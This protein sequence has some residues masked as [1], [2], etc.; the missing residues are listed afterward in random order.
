MLKRL[1]NKNNKK[2]MEQTLAIRKSPSDVETGLV[3]RTNYEAASGFNYLTGIRDVGKLKVVEGIAKGAAC[4]FLKSVM[5]LDQNG[6]LIFDAEVEN[7]TQYSRE[8][9]RKIVLKGMM[10]MLRDASLQAGKS[11]DDLYAFEQLDKLL[12]NAYYQ[13]SYKAILIWAEET[14][15]I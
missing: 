11:F 12:E 1:C 14:G 10:N 13:E 8:T 5:V 7:M 2:Y 6:K 4:I 15:I 9:V 3:I